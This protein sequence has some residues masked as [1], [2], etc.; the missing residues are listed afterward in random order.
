L[1]RNRP[2]P[3]ALKEKSKRSL[4]EIKAPG[5]KSIDKGSQEQ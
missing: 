5:A 3:G 4:I 2:G 1:E